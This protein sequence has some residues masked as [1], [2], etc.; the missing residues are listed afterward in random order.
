M[1][2]TRNTEDCGSACADT[3]KMHGASLGGLGG[4]YRI[5]RE[6]TVG[7]HID[8]KINEAERTMLALRDLRGSLP[9][10]YL[11]SGVSRLGPLGRIA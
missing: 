2:N 7:E 8:A 4:G 5:G 10:S 3:V 1:D 6:Q 11:N 9:G